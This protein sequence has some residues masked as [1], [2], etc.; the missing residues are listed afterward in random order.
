MILY[1]PA[2]LV[3]THS[4]AAQGMRWLKHCGFRR[5]TTLSEATAAPSWL[6]CQVHV[7][8]VALCSSSM[9]CPKLGSLQAA[10]VVS[11]QL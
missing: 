7:A 10:L 1:L 2:A 4:M 8:S 5:S 3:L 11:C 9:P 6:R